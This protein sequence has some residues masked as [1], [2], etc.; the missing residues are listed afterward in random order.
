MTAPGREIRFDVWDFEVSC[1][2]RRSVISYVSFLFIPGLN[3]QSFPLRFPGRDFVVFHLFHRSVKLMCL[4][5]F[6]RSVKSVST[7]SGLSHTIAI[8]LCNR[9]PSFSFIFFSARRNWCVFFYTSF[10]LVFVKLVRTRS[11]FFFYHTI[12]SR[13]YNRMLSSKKI[14]FFR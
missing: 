13:R 4:H 11:G 8:R 6:H 3:P 12:A 10:S 9:M 2:G 14:R 5:L 1:R 7:R